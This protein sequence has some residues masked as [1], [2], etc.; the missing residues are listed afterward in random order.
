M[1][2]TVYLSAA[3]VRN[4]MYVLTR[5]WLLTSDIQLCLFPQNS[6]CIN[7][8]SNVFIL[9]G[10]LLCLRLSSTCITGSIT[11]NGNENFRS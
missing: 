9:A 10:S 2:S 5:V 6:L 1:S 8:N 4:C 3:A 7:W 11:G